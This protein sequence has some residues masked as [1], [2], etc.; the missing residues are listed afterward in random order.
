M[1]PA[2]RKTCGGIATKPSFCTVL[3]S[4]LDI[5]GSSC[6]DHQKKCYDHFTLL[7]TKVGDHAALSSSIQINAGLA[8]SLWTLPI[9]TSL[10]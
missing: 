8:F 3:G 2:S 1:I 9:Q 7:C 10:H 4:A 5:G 6:F